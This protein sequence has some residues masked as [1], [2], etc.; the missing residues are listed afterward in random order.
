[1]NLKRQIM[2]AIEQ[3]LTNKQIVELLPTT[4]NYVVKTRIQ[5]NEIAPDPIRSPV[6]D[7][8]KEGTA[9]RLVYDYL[10]ANCDAKPAE[11]KRATGIDYGIIYSVRKL[12][13]G[14]KPRVNP[15]IA[16]AKALHTVE[17]SELKL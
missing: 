4:L 11:V 16:H 2:A 8:P 9:S 15:W 5:Y 3:G 6:Q 10:K 1:M 17:L 7:K 13:F 12:F 14:H